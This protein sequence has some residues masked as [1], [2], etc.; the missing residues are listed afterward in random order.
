MEAMQR[1]EIRRKYHLKGNCLTDIAVACC[2]VLC[3]LTQQEKEAQFRE[4]EIASGNG[5]AQYSSNNTMTY[6]AKH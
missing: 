3:D 6:E 1:S 5:P 4:A 2:C